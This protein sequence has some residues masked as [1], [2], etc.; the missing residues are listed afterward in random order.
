[1]ALVYSLLEFAASESNRPGFEFW[2]FPLTIGKLL[3][4]RSLIPS[5][6]LQGVIAID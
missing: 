3:S 6:P 1:M 4:S 2:L 5:L